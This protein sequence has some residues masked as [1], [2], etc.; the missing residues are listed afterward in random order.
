[1]G[2]K[3][4]LSQR[5]H[6][7]IPAYS[8]SLRQGTEPPSAAELGCIFAYF[9]SQRSYCSPD[10]FLSSDTEVTFIP[11]GSSRLPI[12]KPARTLNVPLKPPQRSRVTRAPTGTRVP[13]P[14]P[15]PG[16]CGSRGRSPNT[17]TR[18][19]GGDRPRAPRD[20]GGAGGGRPPRAGQGAWVDCGERAG[21]AARRVTEPGRVKPTGRISGPR[22]LQGERRR[23]AASRSA[24]PARPGP[25]P[26]PE[27]CAWKTGG[28][29]SSRSPALTS[30]RVGSGR[31]HL[32]ELSFKL[33]RS[34]GI[35]QLAGR[36][37][38]DRPARE[39][40]AEAEGLETA[41]RADVTA[42]RLR[43]Q[44]RERLRPRRIPARGARGQWR[45]G[46]HVQGRGAAGGGVRLGW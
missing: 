37:A 18:P 26:G 34:V 20:L 44:R 28:S 33:P 36:P 38:P 23:L 39:W 31:R 17:S 27:A 10:S 14:R 46:I 2:I 41:R 21:R 9:L 25:L 7:Q 22:C 32:E 40:G 6:P 1:M 43:P 15:P 45:G 8:D 5:L 16:T 4:T 11:Q 30:S 19:L 24:W 13:A 29:E 12:T 42:R 35:V 3:T